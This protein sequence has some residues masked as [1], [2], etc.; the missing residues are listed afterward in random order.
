MDSSKK[1]PRNIEDIRS[2]YKG[3][4]PR[5]PQSPRPVRPMPVTKPLPVNKPKPVLQNKKP[6]G[7]ID[8]NEPSLINR[9][10][11]AYLNN[12]A[13]NQQKPTIISS[14]KDKKP[15][16]KWSKKRKI[17]TTILSILLIIGVVVAV[18][19]ASL[20][21]KLNKVFHGNLFSDASAFL[22]TQPLKGESSGRVNILLAGNSADDVGHDGGNLT[23]SIMIVS[24]NTKD[25]TGFMLSI[26]RDLWVD[27]PTLGHQ[28]INSA[29][30]VS[31]FNSPGY[32]SNG[33]GQLEQIIQTQLGIPI[34]YYVLIDY[35]AIRDG[36]NAVGGITVN[37]QSSDPRG[38]YD[39]SVDYVTRGPLVKLTNGQHTL[40]GEQAL[41][42][43]RARGDASGSYGFELSDF[44]RTQNQRMMLTALA[45]KVKT[46]GVL[47]NPIRISQLFSALS[48][49]V[50]TDLS[51]NNV[52][53]LAQITKPMDITN[54]QSVSYSYTGMNPLLKGHVDPASGQ[55]AL[56]PSAGVDNFSQL[57][58]YYQQITS[59]NPITRESANV[60]VLN[61]SD[62]VG[63]AST[64]GDMLTNKG[65]SVMSVAS[66]SAKYS[67][68]IIVDMS[69]GKMPATLA[70]LKQL[71]PGNVVSLTDKSAETKEALNYTSADFV[72]I[73]GK[74]WDSSANSTN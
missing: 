55:D 39:P 74:N 24:I 67:S 3:A 52:F 42:L 45:Q 12:P 8:L 6:M 69:D 56:I 28:K 40:N 62:I 53:R 44:T 36:V 48:N 27:I 10:L 22:N 58:A 61:A 66:A 20:L 23:D 16:R 34:N 15:R 25:H 57:Q 41:D 60:V 7:K 73:L 54:V 21:G 35:A 11:P 31:D 72:V 1:T 29:I 32:P 68:T 14:S 64:K 19:G 17:V 9:P 71:F 33:M 5:T 50:H 65:Y 59:S 37:I 70:G 4:Q 46:A 51:L 30:T 43:A 2:R 38:L 63:L 49:N 47:T 18:F 13:S 26:P